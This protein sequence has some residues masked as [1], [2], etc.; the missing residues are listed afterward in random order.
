MDCMLWNP[1][2]CV[3]DTLLV[4][5][6]GSWW[7]IIYACV[8]GSSCLDRFHGPLGKLS[9]SISILWCTGFDN[10]YTTTTDGRGSPIPQLGTDRARSRS[11]SPFRSLSPSRMDGS[12]SVQDIDPEAVRAALRDFVQQLAS[13]ERERVSL[14]NSELLYAGVFLCLLHSY[15]SV[16]RTYVR[17]YIGFNIHQWHETGYCGVLIISV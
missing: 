5:L 4:F 13:A 14:A 7:E 12:V 2:G 15:N 16:L 9:V 1:S 8:E 10:T 3:W 6:M 11:R 17:H